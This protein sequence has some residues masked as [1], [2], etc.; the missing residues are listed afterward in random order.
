[1]RHEPDG[2]LERAEHRRGCKLM[3]N[4]MER[5]VAVGTRVQIALDKHCFD[6]EFGVITEA[7]QRKD[8]WMEYIVTFAD[9][10]TCPY[11]GKHLVVAPIP[12]PLQPHAG[13]VYA[14]SYTNK[15]TVLVITP[16]ERICDGGWFCLGLPIFRDGSFGSVKIV[17]V[18]PTDT[19]KPEPMRLPDVARLALRRHRA[20]QRKAHAA[21]VADDSCER[22][23]FG[24]PVIISGG[25]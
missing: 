18:M 4:L 24:C 11:L 20:I 6:G 15:V 9:G 14:K 7:S 8:G 1:M 23:E 12:K 5:P 19:L 16:I 22:T 25:M 3:T 17:S 13:Q 10:G 21:Y 2:K